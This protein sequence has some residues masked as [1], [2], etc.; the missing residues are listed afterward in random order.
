MIA[1]LPFENLLIIPAG[2][3]SLA[4]F[5]RWV[6]SEEFP[7]EGRIDFIDGQIEV[8]MSPEELINHNTP[9]TEIGGVLWRRRSPSSGGCFRIG[10]G[11]AS[12]RRGSRANRICVLSLSIA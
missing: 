8:D 1:K 3:T 12:A 4:R 9:K 11:L 7:E 2:I 5:V 6:G 10:R